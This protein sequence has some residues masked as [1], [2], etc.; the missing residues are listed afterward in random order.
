MSLFRCSDETPLGRVMVGPRP[1]GIAYDPG[2]R[3]LFVFCIGDPPGANPTVSVVEVDGPRVAAALPLAGRPRWAL[4]DHVSDRVYA[5]VEV[6]P[7][8]AVIDP[9]QP[10]VVGALAVPA[11]GPHGLALT[12]DRLYCAADA[13]ARA[14]Y[15]FC[16][17]SGG[18]AVYADR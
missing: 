2:R 18:V 13:G 10:R 1:N 9:A 7:L 17:R 15:V 11:A 5:N 14:L 6:P 16:P 4:Y 8:I 12:R 3:R